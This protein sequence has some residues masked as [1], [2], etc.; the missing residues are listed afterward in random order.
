MSESNITRKPNGYW[1]LER[2]KASAKPHSNPYAWQ[3]AEGSAY[4]AARKNGWFE[5]CCANMTDSKKPN[6]YWTLERCK[7]SAKPHPN[8]KAWEKAEISAYNAARKN[9][10][11]EICCVNM[12]ELIKP[13][14]YWT[15]ERCKASASPH[16]NVKAWLIADK[17]AYQAAQKNGWL[18]ECCAD[19][20][21]LIKPAGYWTLELCKA[22]AKPHSNPYAWAKAEGSAYNAARKNG[23][24]EIC[25]VNMANKELDVIK[26]L[27]TAG[28]MIGRKPRK[29]K[30]STNS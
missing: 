12:K 26:Y 10:W 4:N 5:E 11:L 8:K 7:A 6:G 28:R 1:T 22:S 16:S 30:T 18:P 20:Q 15:L 25:C 21:E 19:M 13:S 9:G 2:C 3:K 24:L 14:G 27:K 17:A 29:A 23:W